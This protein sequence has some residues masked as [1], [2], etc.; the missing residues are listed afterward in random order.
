MSGPWFDEVAGSSLGRTTRGGRLRLVSRIG[1]ADGERDAVGNLAQ[2]VSRRLVLT[3]FGDR[4]KLLSC[5]YR[6]GTAGVGKTTPAAETLR[7]RDVPDRNLPRHSVRI[8]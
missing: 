8:G 5:L 7:Y 4:T 6:S 2:R 1:A 3:G